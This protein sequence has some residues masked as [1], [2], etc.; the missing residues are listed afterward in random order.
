VEDVL[1]Q[2]PAVKEAA[3]IGI[4]DSYRGETVKAFVTL[5]EDFRGRV[6]PEEPIDFCK[7][8]M[9]AYKY[10]RIVEIPSEIPKPP[11]GSF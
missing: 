8:R 10:P 4:P 1:Y 2:H 5:K 11:P 6:I 9:P 3:V 7:K